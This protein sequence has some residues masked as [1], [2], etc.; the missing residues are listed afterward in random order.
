[1]KFDIAVIGGGPAGIA[2]AIT[3]QSKGRKV[4]LFEAHGFSPRLRSVTEIS[5]YLGLRPMSGTELMDH[6]VAHLS[7]TDVFVVEEKV[8]A[9]VENVAP[10]KE[11][12][13]AAP[14]PQQS[15]GSTPAAPTPQA[16]TQPSG[17][18]APQGQTQQGWGQ[19][20]PGAWTQNPSQN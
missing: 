14:A 13:P 20:Q 1:M 6:F 11:V 17:S 3:A 7:R 4:V 19:T 10:V 8:E 15:W 9:P 16:S 12:A 5:D 2:A 18:W